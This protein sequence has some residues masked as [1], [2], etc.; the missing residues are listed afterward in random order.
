MAM[1]NE[2]NSD[3]QAGCEVA[4]ETGIGLQAYKKWDLNLNLKTQNKVKQIILLG[5]VVG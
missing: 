3:L 5:T 4:G 2:V 1:V